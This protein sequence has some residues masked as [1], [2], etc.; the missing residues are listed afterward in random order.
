M[1]T[2]AQ[3]LYRITDIRNITLNGEPRVGFTA[4]IRAGS[5]YLHLGQFSAPA[6]TPEDALYEH[7]SLDDDAAF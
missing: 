1:T 5:A 2:N 3:P 7:I 6:D 4:Y